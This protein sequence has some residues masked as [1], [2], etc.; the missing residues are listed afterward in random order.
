MHCDLILDLI[1]L[2]KDGIA[3]KESVNAVNEH[4]KGCE[5]CRAELETF[6]NIGIDQFNL[7]DKKIIF[8]IKRS[9]YITQL[10]VLA[11]GAILGIALS[12]SMDMFYNFIIMP[13]IGGVSLI[14]LRKKWFVMPLI[15]FIVTFLWQAILG[16]SVGL[17]YSVAYTILV[18]LGAVIAILLNFAFKKGD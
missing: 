17:Y 7:S 1:P 16:L 9:V 11:V 2:V 13:L 6:E 15:I 8:D 3:S 5:S 12:S 18:A 10:L 14:V 4:V